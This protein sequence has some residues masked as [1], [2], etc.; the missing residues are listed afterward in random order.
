[1]EEAPID[2]RIPNSPG[3]IDT[4]E[5]AV[6]FTLAVSILE[7]GQ[8]KHQFRAGSPWVRVYAM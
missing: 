7:C 2:E 1:M 5:V 3:K 4:K 6:D 8:G